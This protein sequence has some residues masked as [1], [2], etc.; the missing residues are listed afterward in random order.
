M[1]RGLL[2]ME[3]KGLKIVPEGW[4]ETKGAQTEPNGFKW[5][6]NNESRFSNKRKIALIKINKGV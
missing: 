1:H 5:F 3:I 4:T 2:K 6:S